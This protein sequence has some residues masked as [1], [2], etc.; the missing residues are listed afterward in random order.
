MKV[1]ITFPPDIAREKAEE[2]KDWDPEKPM[3]WEA[4][5]YHTV[6][7]ISREG[8]LVTIKTQHTQVWLNKE[9]VEKI[10]GL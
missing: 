3:V 7:K 5:D 9:E 8:D 1:K 10:K 2:A 6:E 4:E